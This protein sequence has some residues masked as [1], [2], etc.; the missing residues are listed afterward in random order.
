MRIIF[1][2]YHQNHFNILKQSPSKLNQF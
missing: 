1:T 2:G